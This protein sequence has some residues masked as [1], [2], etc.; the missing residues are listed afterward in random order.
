MNMYVPGGE[1]C[2]REGKAGVLF[3][4]TGGRLTLTYSNPLSTDPFPTPRGKNSPNI[5]QRHAPPNCLA[6]TKTL[7]GPEVGAAGDCALG[8]LGCVRPSVEDPEK[9]LGA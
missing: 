2:S 4:H 6:T 9:Q 7:S 5:W 8:H 1:V 3:N